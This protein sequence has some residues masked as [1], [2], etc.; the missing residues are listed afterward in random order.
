MRNNAMISIRNLAAEHF[1]VLVH[2]L[3]ALPPNLASSTSHLKK[4][5]APSRQ[6][7][8]RIPAFDSLREY[9]ILVKNIVS[10]IVNPLLVRATCP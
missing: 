10:H 9:S 4:Q 3:E 6:S 7:Q 5:H 8:K 1:F 2:L